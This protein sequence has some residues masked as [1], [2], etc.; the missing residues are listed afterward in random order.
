MLRRGTKLA[1]TVIVAVTAM[2]LPSSRAAATGQAPVVPAG[3]SKVAP[4][5][6]GQGGT[7]TIMVPQDQV[8]YETV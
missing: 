7:T 1:A 3:Q 8:S 2:P 6:Q 4:S 5:A